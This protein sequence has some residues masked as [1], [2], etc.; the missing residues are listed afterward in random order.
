MRFKRFTAVLVAC[1]LACSLLA[2]CGGGASSAPAA[3]TPAAGSTP[4]E[5]G[6]AP[7]QVT[8][9]VATWDYS[10]N[11]STSNAVA[12]FEK[13]HPD[14]KVEVIDIPSADY[15][16]KLSVM[17]NGGELDAYFIK[18]A[19]S[20]LEYYD[21]GQ[22]L[23]LSGYIA[24]DGVDMSE[25]SGTDTPF[26]IDGKQLGMPVRTDYYVLFYNKDI[27]DDAGVAYPSNDMTWKE[28][29]DLAMQLS[30]NGVYG[31]H[32]HTWQACV[33]NWAVQDGEHTIMDY[34]TGYD[35]FKPYYEMVLRLQEAGACQSFGDLQSGSIHYSGAFAAGNVAMLPMGTWYIATIAEAM[36]KGEANMD[37]W[38]VATLP[39]PDGVPAG[40]SVG[41]TTP[42]AIT[43]SSK[44]QD[45]AWEFV[46]FISSETGALEYAKVGAVPGRLSDEI[47]GQ[48]ASLD[49]MPEGLVEAL[50]V[51][52]IAPDRP[53]VPN[54]TEI[55]TM[56]GQEHSLIMLGELSVDEGLAEMAE[57]AA[58]IM[59]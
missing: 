34:E 31:A 4:A 39:H 59:G 17:L 7:E 44:N 13:E 40:Y 43:P 33:E 45:A 42:I 30:G 50:Q 5:G 29:E 36:K 15:Q 22:L 12:L 47:L 41:A 53:I 35:F 58:E 57:R 23:D 3:S 21:R 20:T 24:A 27:F 6:G 9:Q 10:S 2:G 52:N 19:S 32:F 38:G 55:N 14:I 26:N 51:K 11:P 54:V 18:E 49:G 25:Y 37:A 16:T 28:F 1:V 56:L 46:K 8:I 48:I